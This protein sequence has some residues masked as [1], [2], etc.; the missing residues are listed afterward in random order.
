MA[1]VRLGSVVADIRG[2]IGDETYG[3]NQGGI[4]VRSRVTPADPPSAAKT[5]ARNAM[6]VLGAAW[7]GTLT[8]TQR[9]SWI[10]Y[11]RQHPLPNKWGTPR[12]SS[13]ICA[14]TRCNFHWYMA[15]TLIKFPSAPPEPPL[16]QPLWSFT[17]EHTVNHVHPVV[18]IENYPG[19]RR[20]T[21]FHLFSGQ[22][23]TRGRNFYN[24]PWRRAGY[25]HIVGGWWFDPTPILCPWNVISG[26]RLFC[27]IVAQDYDNGQ[28][29]A[30]G[31]AY[32]NT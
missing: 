32:A 17:A 22:P 13:G 28:I 31:Y 4:F 30:P 1:T 5:V 15:R 24:G 26:G 19:P 2:S 6:A 21:A 27:Y 3:R 12:V 29:S 20:P 16:W 14:F 23:V 25:F 18:P 8:E 10:Q 11:G 7:S 9:Q